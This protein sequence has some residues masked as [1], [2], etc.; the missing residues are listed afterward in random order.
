MIKYTPECKDFLKNLFINTEHIK[1]PESRFLEVCTRLYNS[2]YV[3]LA[4][5][6]TY[7]E[8][9]DGSRKILHY[10][11]NFI[12][13]LFLIKWTCDGKAVSSSIFDA[14]ETPYSFNFCTKEEVESFLAGVEKFENYIFYE[15]VQ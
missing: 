14:F 13:L 11:Q 10:K 9:E 7:V 8:K 15:G 4:N 6:Y 12:S 2:E 5:M 3:N 1:D